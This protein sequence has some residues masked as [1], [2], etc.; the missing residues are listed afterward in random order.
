MQLLLMIGIWTPSSTDEEYRTQYPESGIHGVDSGIQ[1]SVGFPYI[2]RAVS[3]FQ[4]NGHT[5]GV[6]L[7]TQK[8]EPNTSPH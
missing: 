5:I 2:G 7:W 4:L 1:G 8:L 6:C 3:S